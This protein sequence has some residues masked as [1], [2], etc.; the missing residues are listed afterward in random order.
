M[1]VF[2]DSL[3][4]GQKLT[5]YPHHINWKNGMPLPQKAKEQKIDLSPHWMEP[6]KKECLAF[7][8]AIETGKQP[9]TDAVEGLQVLRVL[10]RCQRSIEEKKSTPILPASPSVAPEA[11]Y[12]VHETALVDAGA[13]V[14]KSS[15]IWHYSHIMKGAILGEKVTI[16]QNVNVDANA[17]VGNNVKI[18]NN[19]SIYSGVTLEDDVFLGPSCVLTNVSNPRSQVKRHGL[20][21]LTR[22]RR[23]ATVGANATVLCG[24]TIGRYAFISAG[25][26]VTKDVQDYALIRGN[27]GKQVGWMSRHGHQLRD[28]DAEGVYR[29]PESGFRYKEVEP[30]TLKCLDLDEEKELPARHRIG[31]TSYREYKRS[32]EFEGA[33]G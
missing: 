31:K 33:V 24:L 25:A 32:Q 13:I 17:F 3:P 21:E 12:F 16:G 7:L 9:I 18:Q 2:E 14:G 5:L 28:R 4:L 23:G 8:E 27:S 30:G 26:V 19:V 29:C 15:K 22:I 11:P 20:Y 1:L 6:L 10:D